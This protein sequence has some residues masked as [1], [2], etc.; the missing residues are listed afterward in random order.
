MNVYDFDET[1]YGGD[2]TQDFVR[3]LICRQPGLIRYLPRQVQAFLAYS[4]GKLTKTEF[5]SV[6]YTMFEA[7]EGIDAQVE[8]FWDAHQDR[9]YPYYLAQHRPD[10]LVISASP[11][12]LLWPICRRLGISHLLASRVCCQTGRTTGLNCHGP[13]KVHRFIEAG[14]DHNDV[15][16]FYSDSCTDFP[17]AEL[18]EEAYIVQD[19]QV[20]PWVRPE[21]TGLS[22]F[23]QLFNDRNF[24]LVLMASL[25][26][27]PLFLGLA[28]VFQV[29]V[30]LS[31]AFMVAA[32]LTP[33]LLLLSLKV[34]EARPEAGSG[35]GRQI[36]AL[37]FL[38]G[39]GGLLLRRAWKGTRGLPYVGSTV[40][41]LGDI[42][43]WLRRARNKRFPTRK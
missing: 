19:G 26:F 17:L 28:V 14:Y 8:A 4:Q 16:A 18:A 31:V 32:G 29:F 12:F 33:V 39:L 43:F 37:S 41:G 20:G 13:E 9:I 21:K 35:L 38:M 5:K 23:I 2:S 42:Y 10:D 22:A 40:L 36:L 30:P 11:E 3:F 1:I 6:F 27:V 34:F 24:L 7:V 15:E 25:A